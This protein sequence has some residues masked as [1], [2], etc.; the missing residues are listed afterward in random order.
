MT[1]NARATEGAESARS[2][3]TPEPT[4]PAACRLARRGRSLLAGRAPAAL[5]LT[6]CLLLSAGL[7]FPA[8][9]AA[10]SATPSEAAGSGQEGGEEQEGPWSGN[11]DLGVTVTEGN[12]ETMSV[13]LGFRADREVETQKL[14]FAASYLRTTEE[15]EQIASRGEA[16]VK[17]DYFPNDRF[18]FYGRTAAATNEP[19]GLDLRL[20]PGAGVGY[21]FVDS[22]RITLAGETGGNWIREDFVAGSATTS[23]FF[24]AAQRLDVEIN[25]RTT[26]SEEVRYN[27]NASEFSDYLLHAEVTLATMISQAIGLRVTAIDDFDATPFQGGEG[28]EAAE[29]NDFTLITGVTFTF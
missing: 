9:A 7:V 2:G 5:R 29:K 11:A 21:V 27:P 12:S 4:V 16:G 22:E 18:F 20:S 1:P 15:G 28:R 8:S 10:Q 13:S 19:A 6:A 17:Y 3:P 26:L 23:V 14:S 25:E 24:S